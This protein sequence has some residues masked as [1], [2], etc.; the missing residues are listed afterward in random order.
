MSPRF[1]SQSISS[2]NIL[3]WNCHSL[4]NK[5]DL[6]RGTALDLDLHIIALSAWLKSSHYLSFN[7]FHILRKDSNVHNSGGMLLVKKSIPFKQITDPFSIQDRLD[8]IGVI[9]S[10]LHESLLSI[11]RYLHDSISIDD[12]NGLFQYCSSFTHSVIVFRDFNAHHFSWG[13][14]RKL[15]WRLS[16]KFSFLSFF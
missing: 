7:N 16:S 9:I 13:Y 1:E 14:E 12:W 5:I 10:L 3:Q 11:Y 15:F 4:L 2:L 8:S 6:L